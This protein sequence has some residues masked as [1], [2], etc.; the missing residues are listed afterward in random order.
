MKK[1]HTQNLIIIWCSVFALSMVSL[2]GFGISLMALKGSS[3]VIISGIISTIGYFLHIPDDK[4]ALLLVFP[5]AIGTLVYSWITGGNSIPYMANYVLLAM[6]TS[7]FIETVIIYF[8]VPFTVISVVFMIFSPETIA[9][10]GATMAGVVSRIFMFAVTAVLLYFATKRGAQVVKNTEEALEQVKQNA[11][12]AT[13]ISS[14]LNTTIKR[15]MESVHELAEGSS[16]V[17]NAA[18]QMGEVVEDTAKSTVTVMD[19]INAATGEIN[20]NHELATQLDGG[21]QKVQEAVAQGNNAVQQ[22]KSSILEMEQT[23][24]SARQSTD[25]LLTEM[26]K[27]TSI[28]GEINSIASQTNLLSLNAS[29]EAA[30]A[31]EHGRGFAVVADEIRSLSEESAKS[32]NNIQDILKWL[33]ETTAQV[34]REIT[35]GTDAAAASVEMVNGLLEYFG[36]INSAADDASRTVSEEYRIIENVKEHFTHIQEEIETLVATSEE[37][38]A[39]I[40]NITETISA[41]NDSISSISDEIEEIATLSTDLENHFSG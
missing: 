21:F 1:L 15:S 19:K 34:A 26:N 24:D 23:V 28:L 12:V 38:A 41:Q 39:T 31:G 11:S 18:E 40:Q 7:Y 22:A 8:A 6:T 3:V 33:T 16:S 25:S 30:R 27:I 36:N 29:I 2:M 9:G 20:R 35:A 10:Q 5:P 13:D 17:K 37:N 4:K 14:N 32:A